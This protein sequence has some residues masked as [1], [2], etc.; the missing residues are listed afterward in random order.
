M[1]CG[2]SWASSRTTSATCCID[3]P[4]PGLSSTG[5]TNP[6]ACRPSRPRGGAPAGPRRGSPGRRGP[7]PA[8]P[9]TDVADHRRG[10]APVG[11]GEGKD[12]GEAAA[13]RVPGVHP[14]QRLLLPRRGRTAR[15]SSGS[16]TA[17]RN[18]SREV[19]AVE[20]EQRRLT[21]ADGAGVGGAGPTGLVQPDGRGHGQHRTLRLP[22]CSSPTLCAPVSSLRWLDDG[23]L[24]GL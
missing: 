9:L 19:P 24:A 22:M 13:Q 7:D 8:F 23:R 4:S 16:G 15:A 18:G 11:R 5:P 21:P 14:L 1:R 12:P 2:C 6:W 3:P 20:P 17:R 10:L